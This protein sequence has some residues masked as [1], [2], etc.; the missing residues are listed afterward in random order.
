M[1]KTRE[2]EPAERAKGQGGG[3]KGTSMGPLMRFLTNRIMDLA[4][5]R[6]SLFFSLS[7]PFSHSERDRSRRGIKIEQYEYCGMTFYHH[8]RNY[9]VTLLH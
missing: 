3:P 5:F 2:N 9:F 1:G 8:K 6:F 7:S 4:I